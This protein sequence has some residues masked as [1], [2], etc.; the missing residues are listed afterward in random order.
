MQ[1]CQFAGT[2][3]RLRQLRERLGIARAIV[4]PT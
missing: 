1:A 3:V 4:D 2:I